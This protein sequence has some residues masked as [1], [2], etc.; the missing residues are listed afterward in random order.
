MDSR[1]ERKHAASGE[2]IYE[3]QCGR[4][5]WQGGTDGG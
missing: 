2:R 3:S 1:D 5:L 4:M